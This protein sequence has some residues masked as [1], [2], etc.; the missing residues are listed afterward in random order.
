[1][2]EYIFYTAEG[3]T[4]APNGEEIENCQLLG[5]AWGTNTHHALQNLLRDN[6]WIE[7]KGFD[8]CNAICRELASTVNEQEKLSYLTNL[9]DERQLTQYIQ[10]L[11]SVE[12]K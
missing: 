10:W 9:L 6:P 8:P 12:Q 3:F 2:R 1:M 11:K 7:Q 5:C 4:Q